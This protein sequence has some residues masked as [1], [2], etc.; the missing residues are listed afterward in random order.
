M[1]RIEINDE[2]VTGAL[3]RALA[4]AGDLTPF[5]RD[6]GDLLVASTQD[7]MLSAKDIDRD[8]EIRRLLK[9]TRE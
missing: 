3:T 5:M 9:R 4:A 7:R 2:Q 8:P 6:L 1:I